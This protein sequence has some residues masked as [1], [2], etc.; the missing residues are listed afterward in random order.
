M[1][2]GG[3]VVDWLISQQYVLIELL[4]VIILIVSIVVCPFHLQHMGSRDGVAA[5]IDSDTLVRID[6]M[7]KLCDTNKAQVITE[8]LTLVYDINPELHRNYLPKE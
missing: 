5:K 6:E 3:Q 1:Y 8:L 2:I 7:H 4:P